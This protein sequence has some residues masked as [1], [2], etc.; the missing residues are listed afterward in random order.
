MVAGG[1]LASGAAIGAQSVAT[2]GVSGLI[3]PVSPNGSLKALVEHPDS[4]REF[5]KH[6]EG[7]ISDKDTETG[8]GKSMIEA[9]HGMIK[10][11]FQ[12]NSIKLR[13][14]LGSCWPLFDSISVYVCGPAK[15]NMN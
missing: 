12:I 5:A 10:L 11:T 14:H 3:L 13:I 8:L 6:M 1:A 15:Y 2:G 7:K 4:V 9:M